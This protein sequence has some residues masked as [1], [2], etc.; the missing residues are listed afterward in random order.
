MKSMFC[1]CFIYLL[2]FL[3]TLSCV[4]LNEEEA[5]MSGLWFGCDC[6]ACCL[7]NQCPLAMLSSHLD[8]PALPIPSVEYH[9]LGADLK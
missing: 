5:L 6:R 3:S 7:G 4:F 2:I 1:A 9:P 8:M